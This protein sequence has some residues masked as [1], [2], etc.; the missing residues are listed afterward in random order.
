MNGKLLTK[1]KIQNDGSHDYPE[2]ACVRDS[3]F[4]TL[5]D[6]WLVPTEFL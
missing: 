5:D 6:L 2:F 3:D 1:C 4:V